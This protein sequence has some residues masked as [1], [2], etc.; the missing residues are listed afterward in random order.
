M[1]NISPKKIL[2]IEDDHD[3]RSLM[4]DIIR[5]KGYTYYEAERG[6]EGI[7]LAEKYKPDLILVDL[8]LPDMQGYEVTTHLKGITELKD[9]PIIALTGFKMKI[10]H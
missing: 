5:Y 9:T 2:Y 3:T 10:L 7:R 8:M 6:L 4:G 1:R